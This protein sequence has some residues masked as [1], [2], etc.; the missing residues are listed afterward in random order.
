METMRKDMAAYRATCETEMSSGFNTVDA[1]AADDDDE[2]EESI[3]QDSLIDED[4]D[5]TFALSL[6]FRLAD[7]DFLRLY[8][9]RCS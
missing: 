3:F 8:Y 9:G 6:L 1:A 4:E 5:L 2:G 7:R